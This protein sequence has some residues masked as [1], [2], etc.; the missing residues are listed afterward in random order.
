MWLFVRWLLTSVGCS[1]AEQ[2][3]HCLLSL[4]TQSTAHGAR[5]LPRSYLPKATG[6]IQVVM[7]EIPEQDTSKY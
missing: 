7:L 3:C 1:K 6:F 5:N 4:D 2:P